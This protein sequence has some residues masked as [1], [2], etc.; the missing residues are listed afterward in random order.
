[1][2]QICYRC[3]NVV[4]TSYSKSRY[5]CIPVAE[6][7][8]PKRWSEVFI[9]HITQMTGTCAVQ[10]VR[11]L[12]LLQV[13]QLPLPW[14]SQL[15]PDTHT[16]SHT[17]LPY[18]LSVF[19]QYLIPSTESIC[20]TNCWR[21]LALRPAYHSIIWTHTHPLVPDLLSPPLSLSSSAPFS[22]SPPSSPV[23]VLLFVRLVF[24]CC[25]LLHSSCSVTTLLPCFSHL[26]SSVVALMEGSTSGQRSE[27]T[28]SHHT[29]L[30]RFLFNLSNTGGIIVGV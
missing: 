9:S 16:F 25:P 19:S 28:G 1:M 11:R 8:N 7:T 14:Q 27:I 26:H 17:S 30:M 2:V 22:F 10:Y 21:T 29:F 24:S 18:L 6:A 5:R 4:C 23:S 13:K 15:H 20:Q 3:G 12:L